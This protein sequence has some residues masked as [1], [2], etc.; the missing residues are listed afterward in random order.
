MKIFSFN[1]PWKKSIEKLYEFVISNCD[2]YFGVSLQNISFKILNDN[3]NEFVIY[4]YN[5]SCNN[6]HL[7]DTLKTEKF[8]Y[9]SETYKI[10]SIDAPVD[11]TVCISNGI[12]DLPPNQIRYLKWDKTTL[13][14]QMAIV[15]YETCNEIL[16]IPKHNATMKYDAENDCII[17]SGHYQKTYNDNRKSKEI[18]LTDIIENFYL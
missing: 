15:H 11:N 4:I 13:F 10:I 14:R 18:D 5:D 1:I 17:Y 16:K 12:T 9:T 2:K 6:L 7:I 3:R 8:K